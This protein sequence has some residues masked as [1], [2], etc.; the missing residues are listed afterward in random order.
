VR[1]RSRNRF[2]KIRERSKARGRSG[3]G[4]ALVVERAVCEE[5]E[6]R[7]MVSELV[8][9]AVIQLVRANHLRWREQPPAAVAK[10]PLRGECGMLGERSALF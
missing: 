3:T 7:P 4:C 9:L 10:S 1:A 6:L 5:R 2:E 8:H